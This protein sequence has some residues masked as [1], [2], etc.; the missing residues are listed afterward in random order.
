[1]VEPVVLWRYRFASDDYVSWY[2]SEPR[3]A[4]NKTVVLRYRLEL[5]SRLRAAR[6][7][8]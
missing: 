2:C 7:P 5:E 3:L 8:D 6:Q 1:M 4:F